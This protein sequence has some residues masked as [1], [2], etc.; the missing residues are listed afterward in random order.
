MS[1]LLRVGYLSG[2]ENFVGVSSVAEGVRN[3]V[4]L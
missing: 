1:G 4:A 3:F 2:V